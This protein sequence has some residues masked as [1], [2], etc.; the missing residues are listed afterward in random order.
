MRHEDKPSENNLIAGDLLTLGLTCRCL[1]HFQKAQSKMRNSHTSSLLC[2]KAI[3]FK[4]TDSGRW[5]ETQPAN[6]ENAAESKHQSKWERKLSEKRDRLRYCYRNGEWLFTMDCQDSRGLLIST[7]TGVFSCI[8]YHQIS[9]QQLCSG[10]FLSHPILITRF[11][12]LVP[13]FPLYWDTDLAQLAVQSGC[14]TICGFSVLQSF[15]EKCRQ[16]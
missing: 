6:Q 5:D 9:N 13:F 15:F 16:S 2:Y 10:I 1:F 8:F 12:C 3:S 11:E 4:L 14:C 7:H